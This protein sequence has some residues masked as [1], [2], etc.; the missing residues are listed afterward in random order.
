MDLLFCSSIAPA[1]GQKG[2]TG[3][4]LG[5]GGVRQVRRRLRARQRCV[6]VCVAPAAC[7]VRCVARFDL[8]RQTMTMLDQGYC[9]IEGNRCTV[10][11]KGFGTITIIDGN[12][13]GS[14]EF[15]MEYTWNSCLDEHHTVT[16][17]P[18]YCG[19]PCYAVPLT[20]PRG[21]PW[22]PAMMV[23]AACSHPADGE[24]DVL[25]CRPDT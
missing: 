19:E 14:I 10:G 8:I 25:F 23:R 4:T 16:G 7:P 11:P 24:K 3:K 9:D 13:N 17:N 21:A 5:A 2:H 18:D 15:P 12:D 1:A 6:T 22:P 20:Q